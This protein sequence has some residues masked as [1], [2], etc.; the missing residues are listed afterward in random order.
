MTRASLH[1]YTSSASNVAGSLWRRRLADVDF[2]GRGI[3]FY[4]TIYSRADG[5]FLRQIEVCCVD[6]VEALM[7]GGSLHIVQRCAQS[8][9]WLEMPR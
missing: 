4:L 8:S 7:P 9:E 5:L 3:K 2:P 1:G 6:L